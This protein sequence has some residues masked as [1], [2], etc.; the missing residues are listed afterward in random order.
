MAYHGCIE[1][2]GAPCINESVYEKMLSVLPEYQRHIRNC[3][4]ASLGYDAANAECVL[5]N[6][7]C[8]EYEGHFYTTGLNVFDVRKPCIGNVCYV[9]T[10]T[11]A[12]FN[13]SAT[14]TSLGVSSEARWSMYNFEVTDYFTY[15]HM[16]N[17][18]WTIP[19]LLDAGIRVLIYAG[20]CDFICNW[21]G[22]KAWVKALQWSGTAGFNAAPD[23]EFRVGGRAAGQER[24]YG[25]FSFVRV[26]D[27]GHMV[28]MDQP[29][30]SLYMVHQFLHDRRLA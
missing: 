13:N 28:P 16:K 18:N 29:Q 20:D 25:N 11:L 14:Q 22:N 21:I 27:A 10:H 24:A 17:F 30:T 8:S 9:W 19:P 6:N 23:V 4:D 2:T 1:K 7:M 12:L 5:A 15:D 3:N 26:Y